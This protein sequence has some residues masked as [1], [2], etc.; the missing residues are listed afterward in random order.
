MIWYFASSGEWIS[1]NAVC[2]STNRSTSAPWLTGNYNPAAFVPHEVGVVTL[3]FADPSN[4]VMTYTI[5]GVTQ[6]KPISR[7]LF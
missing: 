3:T 2:V 5:D 6:S 1:A 7:F 4:A